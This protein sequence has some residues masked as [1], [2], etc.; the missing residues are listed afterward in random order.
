MG[1]NTGPEAPRGHLTVT[2]VLQYSMVGSLLPRG[3][4]SLQTEQTAELPQ[5]WI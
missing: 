1:T 3:T 4:H 2:C 5:E